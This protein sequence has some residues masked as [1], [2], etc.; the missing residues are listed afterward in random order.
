[1]RCGFSTRLSDQA[2]EQRG[3]QVFEEVLPFLVRRTIGVASHVSDLTGYL[4]PWMIGVVATGIAEL[5]AYGSGRMLT[6]RL[7]TFGTDQTEYRRY[8]TASGLEL[9]QT[10]GAVTERLAGSFLR[11]IGFEES[12]RVKPLIPD[13]VPDDIDDSG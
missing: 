7:A 11:S 9:H 2:D 3:Q 13:P 1:M 12:P 8:T 4:G 10:P 6:S 5:S